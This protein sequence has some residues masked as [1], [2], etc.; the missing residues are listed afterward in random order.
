ML[1]S[2]E[3]FHPLQKLILSHLIFQA[4]KIG[5]HKT[6]T[7]LIVLLTGSE[8]GRI[9]SK[10]PA[11]DMFGLEQDEVNITTKFRINANRNFT[12]FCVTW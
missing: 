3:R 1:D 9:I 7:L 12:Q 4:L 11:E 6:V 5:T 8:A 10:Q 2:V